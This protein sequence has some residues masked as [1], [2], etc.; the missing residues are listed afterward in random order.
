MKNIQATW[1]VSPSDQQVTSYNVYHSKVGA[2]PKLLAGTT[3]NVSILYPAQLGYQAGDT[4]QVSIA[5]VNATGE[6]PH[7]NVAQV[8]LPTELALPSEVTGLVLTLV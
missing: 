7:M 2:T 6:G 5:A 3:Q 4:V 1:D 8:T